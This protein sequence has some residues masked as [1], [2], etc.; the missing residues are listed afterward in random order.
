MNIKV[1]IRLIQKNDASD[2]Q[3]YAA[4]SEVSK[5]SNVPYPYPGD[6]GVQFVE[7]V[8]ASRNAGYQ[9][10]FSIRYGDNF[11]GVMT[12]NSVD[13]DGGMAELD[14]WVAVPFWNKG[15]ATAAAKEAIRYAFEELGLTTLYSS[16]L[17]RNPASAR[18]LE[19]NGFTQ[20]SEFVNDGRFGT[21]F[22]GEPMKRFRLFRADWETR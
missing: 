14:Y 4:D 13:R 6:G 11:A 3:K 20:I 22:E 2:V 5:T 21:K 18:V 17:V 12:L 7:R 1:T 19:K 16:C 15:I 10:A 8:I 9:H